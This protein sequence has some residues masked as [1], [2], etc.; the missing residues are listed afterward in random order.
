MIAPW[1]AY[2]RMSE[3][4]KVID[5]L[6]RFKELRREAFRNWLILTV[7]LVGIE[8]AILYPVL[9]W[10]VSMTP[11]DQQLR[12]KYLSDPSASFW[13]QDALCTAL[14]RDPV[15][16]LNDAEVLAK[17]LKERW[18]AMV[19]EEAKAQNIAVSPNLVGDSRREV[20]KGNH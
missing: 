1:T 3:A 11:Y 17:V 4:Q 20:G 14:D 5:A 7:W 9:R 16:A 2:R 18:D 12:C 10:G 8:V 19:A 15:D 13:F 6:P